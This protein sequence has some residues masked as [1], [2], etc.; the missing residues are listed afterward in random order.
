MGYEIGRDKF[1]A[2]NFKKKDGLKR[3]MQLSREWNLYR[4]NYCGCIYSIR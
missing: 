3:A 1:F 4:Q 2:R